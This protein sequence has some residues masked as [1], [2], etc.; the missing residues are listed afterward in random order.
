M[1]LVTGLF[2]LATAV[3]I[4]VPAQ[5]LPHFVESKGVTYAANVD[6]TPRVSA[7][8][9]SGG[10]LLWL[11]RLNTPPLPPDISLSL[12]LEKEVLYVTGYSDSLAPTTGFVWALDAATG[13]I[14]WLTSMAGGGIYS[15]AAVSKGVVYVA[16]GVAGAASRMSALDAET[17]AVLWQ[18]PIPRSYASP[19]IDRDT[20][21]LVSGGFGSSTRLL[22]FDAATGAPLQ[23][24]PVP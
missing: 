20:V 21:V 10:S 5:A 2:A 4:A 23:D 17:G 24:A 13:R 1:K 18:S 6:G 14:L 15:S 7:L 16:G 8:V 22:V 19:T 12:A 9:T 3:A 11:T